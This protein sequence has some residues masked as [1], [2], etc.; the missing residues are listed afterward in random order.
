MDV[1][2]RELY[3]SANGDRWYLACDPAAVVFIRHEP[4]RASGGKI[5]NIEIGTFLSQPGQSPDKQE[6]LRLIATLVTGSSKV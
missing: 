5:S 1:E 3:H 4:N 2:T 6:L